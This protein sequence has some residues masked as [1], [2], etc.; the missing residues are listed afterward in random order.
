MKQ[1]M[2]TTLQFLLIIV[3]TTLIFPPQARAYLDP[4]NGSN[5]FQLLLGTILGTATTLKIYR[6]KICEKGKQLSAKLK[7]RKSHYTPHPD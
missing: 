2:V 4:G 3:I 1:R 6:K 5:I 7:L